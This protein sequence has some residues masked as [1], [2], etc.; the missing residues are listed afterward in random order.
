MYDIFLNQTKLLVFILL[1]LSMIFTLF[2]TTN[3]IS[4]LKNNKL[5]Y[6]YMIYQ[7]LVLFIQLFAII[8]LWS[9]P[10]EFVSVTRILAILSVYLESLFLILIFSLILDKTPSMPFMLTMIAIPFIIMNIIIIE[11]DALFIVNGNY[12]IVYNALYYL[13]S[14][15]KYIVAII[16][17]IIVYVFIYRIKNKIKISDGIYG[18]LIMIPLILDVVSNVYYGGK[19]VEISYILL[20][21][22]QIVLLYTISQKW[23][24][25]LLD[26]IQRNTLDLIDGGVLILNSYGI[27]IYSNKNGILTKFEKIENE[28]QLKENIKQI[29]NID[30][31]IIDIKI[32][33]IKNE[34]RYELKT[35][36]NDYY[37]CIINKLLDEKND[38]IG[39]I[40]SFI[41]IT[42]YKQ[43][44]DAMTE[45]NENLNKANK[46]LENQE[47]II[48]NLNE[49]KK[50]EKIS[51]E[52]RDLL[53]NTMTQILTSLSAS[54][55]LLVTDKIKAKSSLVDVMDMA[56]EYLAQ[57]R[58]MVSNLKETK[59]ET[60]D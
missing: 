8:R 9:A 20:F 6:P 35:T 38:I 59:E 25:K 50:K 52:I 44:I 23:A 47:L 15:Y 16:S 40:V 53:A 46:E 33:N 19:L 21:T 10:A 48:S 54:E 28:N 56:K 2:V 45:K 58:N 43:L 17:I 26:N 42:E 4:K 36:E 1:F 22:T 7:L 41:D 34:V 32:S 14:I 51:Q 37:S 29:A 13:K 3:I 57:V 18:I 55:I 60:N 49:M 39:A 27:V 30:S 5:I 31:N 11:H 12:D 24:F